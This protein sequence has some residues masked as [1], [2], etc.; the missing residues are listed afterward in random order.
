MELFPYTGCPSP[1]TSKE[2]EPSED[3]KEEIEV[4]PPLTFEHDPLE[5]FPLFIH[6]VE[7][8]SSKSSEVTPFYVTLQVNSSLLRNC[9][10]HPNATTNIMTEEIMHRLGLSLS[11]PNTKGGFA[12][13]NHQGSRSCL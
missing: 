1:G 11:R 8:A 2:I 6:Q 3:K 10:L 12:K 5:E 7:N 4:S 13:G 9:V